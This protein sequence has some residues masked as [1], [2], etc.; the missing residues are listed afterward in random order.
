MQGHAIVKKALLV[1][2]VGIVLVVSAEIPIVRGRGT[3][4]YSGR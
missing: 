4:E 2:E 3:E 1:T